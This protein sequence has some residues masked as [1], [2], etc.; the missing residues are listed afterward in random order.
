MGVVR[1][2]Q[3][4]KDDLIP[5]LALKHARTDKDGRSHSGRVQGRKGA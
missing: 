3:K 4:G 5:C 2:P 1:T